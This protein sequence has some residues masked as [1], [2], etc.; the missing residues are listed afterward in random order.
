M[1]DGGGDLPPHSSH[2]GRIGMVDMFRKWLS[3]NV[4]KIAWDIGAVCALGLFLAVAVRYGLLDFKSVDYFASLKPWYNIIK[5]QGFSAFAT[6]FSNYN[7][8][9]LYLLYVIIRF[10]P[11]LPAVIAVK[12]PSLCAD[13]ILAY[14]VYRIVRLKTTDPMIPALAGLAVLF[15]PTVMTNGAFWGQADSLYTAALVGCLYY[16]LGGRPTASMLAYGVAL[17]FK[18]QAIFL[19]PWLCALFLR[20]SIGGRQLLLIPVVLFLAI[21]P[22]WMA[23]RP[24]VELLNIYTFQTSQFESITMNAPS[25]YTW[26]PQTK[27][28]FNLFYQPGLLLAAAMAFL[29]IAVVYKSTMEL[30]PPMLLELALVSVMTVPFFL[31]KMHERYFFPADVLSIVYAFYFPRFFYVALGMNAI[32][33]LSY[34]PYL[35]NAEPI[36]F[37]LLT[38]GLLLLIS[39]TARHAFVGLYAGTRSTPT[40]DFGASGAGR[41]VQPGARIENVLGDS[42]MIFVALALAVALRASL[43]DFKSADYYE[44]TR[45]WYN[46]LKSEGFSAFST[47]FA[48][49]NPPYLYA[50]YVLIRLFPDLPRHIAVKIPSLIADFVTAW[51]A[52]RIARLK[53]L[54]GP[55]PL[56]TAFALLFA[57]TIVLNSAFWGQ[58]DALYTSM[59]LA[60]LY[61]VLTRKHGL[62]MLAFGVAVSFKAQALFLLP[63]VLALVFKKE[64]PRRALF[65]ILLPMVLALLPSWIAGRPVGSLLNIYLAQVEQYQQ[66]TMHAPSLFALMPDGSRTYPYFYPLGLSVSALVA[67]CFILLVSRSKATLSHALLI[68]LALASV[69]MMPLLLPKMHERYFYPAD[70]ISILFALYSPA[71][72]PIPMA[73]SLISFFAYQP[74]LFGQEPIPLPFLALAL[75]AVACIVLW[76]TFR[77]LY[78]DESGARVRR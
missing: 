51:F 64:I 33:F 18:L 73:V 9:Y 37:P 50:L 1:Q 67:L 46:T 75:L 43:L 32:S 28:V 40:N 23:G 54:A 15:A 60:S 3:I 5:A 12:I 62:S 48:N 13:F 4:S 77:G 19:A 55:L 65:L 49:Y 6:D 69:I 70:V 68:E 10:F 78:P 30:T 20:R 25:V 44:Y 57:P 53:H 42:I 11:D 27:Q 21:L 74:F 39:L 24:L 56:F 2:R 61:G 72:Y 31:P 26:L 38:L 29:F 35:F 58:A 14:F 36:P 63:L 34:E 45:V 66:L 17:A 41:S 8:P 59:L 47:D 16:L 76:K 71:Y 22:S 7:P 52:Y